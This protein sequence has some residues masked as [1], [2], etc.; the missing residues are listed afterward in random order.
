MIRNL[1][2]SIL[3]LFFGAV[4]CCSSI[5][6][7]SGPSDR[8]P[9]PSEANG[10]M[11]KG[12]GREDS[13]L[14]AHRPA[15][16]EGRVFPAEAFGALLRRL[17][18]RRPRSGGLELRPRDRVAHTLGPI[19]AYRG[20][21]GGPTRRA[22]HRG[23]FRKDMFQGKPNIVAQWA[24][25]HNGSAQ[26]WVKADATH[27]AYVDEW[28]KKHPGLVAQWV[29]ENPDTPKPRRRTS[30]SSSSRASR[31]TNPGKFP[32]PVT[33]KGPTA[34]TQ[35]AIEPAAAGPTSS[36]PSSTCGCRNIR[37]PTLRTFPATL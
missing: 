25:L 37:R 4:I 30:P 8:L 18:L 27:G 1:S 7:S 10:S 9:S 28:A 14:A 33:R 36:R 34:R 15:L 12:P 2:K 35:T 13:R 20:G 5:P 22:R 17:G 32:S 29:K 3:L 23:W 26:G 6:L 24:D 31:R 16:H 11:V 21:R 19:A